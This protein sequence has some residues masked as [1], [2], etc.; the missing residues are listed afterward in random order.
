MNSHQISQYETIDYHF[1]KLSYAR[2]S[3]NDLERRALVD[4]QTDFLQHPKVVPF[5]VQN[6][7]PGFVNRRLRPYLLTLFGTYMH[8]F[9]LPPQ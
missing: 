9:L 7:S 6:L 2:D 5:Y 1:V 8:L 4:H 3:L